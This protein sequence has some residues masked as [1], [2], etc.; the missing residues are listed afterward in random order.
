MKG[1][2]L[3]SKVNFELQVLASRLG[4]GMK[5]KI[6]LHYAAC[7]MII[8][9]H[10]CPCVMIINSHG[11]PCVMITNSHGCPCVMITNSHGCPCGSQQSL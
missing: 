8:N 6:M 3:D 4:S 11:C 10:G 5:R 1:L 2:S 9:S 7:V